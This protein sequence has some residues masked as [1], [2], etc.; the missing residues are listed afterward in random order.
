MILSQ[1]I[2]IGWYVFA[3]W[4]SAVL[5]WF[6][7]YGLRKELLQEK[8]KLQEWFTDDNLIKG[9]FLLPVLWVCLYFIA[10]TYHSI[11]KKSR[12]QEINK[13][14]FLSLS[15][16]LLVF[17]AILLDD[18]SSSYHYY[19]EAILILFLL[20]FFITAFFRFI[21]LTIV[22]WQIRTGA[23]FFKTLVIGNEKVIEKINAES[24]KTQN[25]NGK[26]ITGF[27]SIEQNDITG[28]ENF[29][30]L[31]NIPVILN[32][33][34]PVE[35]ILA[36]SENDPELL[37]PVLSEILGKESVI[38]VVPQESDYFT[39][40]VQP[41]DI[42]TGSFI[43]IRQQAMPY[44]QQNIK[45]MLD[46]FF[47]MFFLIALSPIIVYVAV[48][49]QWSSKGPV[50]IRQTRLGK[51]EKPFILYKFRSMIVNAEPDGP[52]LSSDFD[53][54]IT[55]WGKTMR[56]WR[57]DELPQLWNVLKG[58]MSLV[59]PRPERSF[60]ARKIL[61]INPYYKL[62]YNLKPGI[63]SWGMVQFGYAES[64]GQM[65]ERMQYDLLYVN[66]ASLL[67][68]LKILIHT[69]RIILLGKGK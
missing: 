3:D 44:W 64:L 45:R 67:L 66:N 56:K 4:L 10:G 57:L 15:G 14:F 21:I 17:F 59:G 19:L 20:H 49:T 11:Y 34:K 65:L 5:T 23:V 26:R 69:V 27:F 43:T 68:D 25:W 46:I 12:L 7:F 9:I 1:K 47:S 13:L 61:A 41:D 30:S 58:D 28:L 55:K 40:A 22:K 16:N 51:H 53:P 31:E 24:K 38:K 39:G 29:G 48:R 42:I 36:F 54:R 32:K 35:I 50:W 37:K 6:I 8:S 18:K 52:Q 60:Y 33:E 2:R 63:T 62:L